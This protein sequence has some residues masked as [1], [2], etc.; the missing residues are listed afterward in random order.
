[1]PALFAGI[2]M[3]GAAIVWAVRRARRPADEGAARFEETP[4][5]DAEA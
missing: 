2:A 3:I 4:P 5:E 1:M